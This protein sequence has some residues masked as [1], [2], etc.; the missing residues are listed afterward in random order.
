MPKDNKRPRYTAYGEGWERIWGSG[1]QPVTK[2]FVCGTEREGNLERC[3]QCSSTWLEKKF[4]NGV[5]AVDAVT[6]S[7]DITGAL[8]R[9]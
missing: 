8:T 3:P 9:K 2:C 1:Y 7:V 4:A 6:G 5:Y